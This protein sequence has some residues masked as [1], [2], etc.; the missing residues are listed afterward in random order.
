MKT[1]SLGF[2]NDLLTGLI[3]EITE[4]FWVWTRIWRDKMS[5]HQL[6]RFVRNHKTTNSWKPTLT[7]RPRIRASL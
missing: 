6:A 5:F 1:T 2:F 4:I 3:V 7:T